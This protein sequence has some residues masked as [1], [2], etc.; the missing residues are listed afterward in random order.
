M[1]SGLLSNIDQYVP[2]MIAGVVSAIAFGWRV[3]RKLDIFMASHEQEIR[4]AHEK[5]DAEFRRVNERLKGLESRVFAG[6]E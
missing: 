4:F 2:M 5:W 1:L 6:K 3:E